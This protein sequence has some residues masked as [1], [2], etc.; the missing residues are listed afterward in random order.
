[1]KKLRKLLITTSMILLICITS[2]TAA[3]AYNTK[4]S[5]T[6]QMSGNSFLTGETR[7]FKKGTFIVGVRPQLITNSYTYLRVSCYKSGWWSN[8]K[9]GT[10]GYQCLSVQQRWYDYNFGQVGN[11]EYFNE[12]DTY[13]DQRWNPK[14]HFYAD[15]DIYT[16]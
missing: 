15:V 16:T 2:A 4:Y 7:E 8:S 13:K 10:S 14:P 11:G 6:L 3:F 12:F 5:T 9:I 1:M